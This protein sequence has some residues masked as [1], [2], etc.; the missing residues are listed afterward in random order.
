MMRHRGASPATI[1]EADHILLQGGSAILK[2]QVFKL[3]FVAFFN[4][5]RTLVTTRQKQLL[6][7]AWNPFP[8]R[9]PKLG[10]IENPQRVLVDPP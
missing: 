4:P 2:V 3:S 9:A 10:I 8:E 5:S 6:A 7:P 1:I